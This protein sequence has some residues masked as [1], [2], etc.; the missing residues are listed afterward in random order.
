MLIE[1]SA[2]IGTDPVRV[3]GN[4]ASADTAVWNG[5]VLPSRYSM[6]CT[7]LAASVVDRF[8][9]TGPRYQPFVPEG[10]AGLSVAVDAAAD[11]ASAPAAGAATASTAAGIVAAM[12]ERSSKRFLP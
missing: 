1:P 6:R 11:T 9:V 10:V 12:S 4:G 2:V 3:A 8:S 5:A 7:P